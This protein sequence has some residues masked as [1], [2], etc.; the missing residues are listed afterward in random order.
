[1]AVALFLGET[2][3][4]LL[5]ERL[6]LLVGY[7]VSTPATLLVIGFLFAVML[8]VANRRLKVEEDPRIGQV[9]EALPGANCG[10]CGFPGCD[11][12]AEELVAGRAEPAGCVVASAEAIEAISRILGIEAS[13]AVPKRAVV[14]CTAKIQ[15]RLNRA[16]YMGPDTC[17]AMNVLAGVQ[18]CTYGCLG[19]GDCMRACPFDAITMREGLPVIDYAACTG[20]GN[21]VDACP[22]GIISLEPMLED[23]LMVVACNSRDP[24]KYVRAN[25]RVGCTGCGVCAKLDPEAFI[26]E[27]ELSRILYEPEKYGS[28]RDHEKAA[29]KCPT[30][31]ILKVGTAIPDPYA[32]IEERAKAKAAKKAQ[33]QAGA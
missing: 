15:D 28:T 23:P 9:R 6:A 26:V 11:Q 18:G 30:S 20:C 8:S 22:R 7:G 25:C 29:E 14:H 32:W 21:C 2:S 27:N 19:L 10:G 31:C 12:F 3:L 24:I 33:A 16:Q 13:T 5:M 1:M 17:A 4:R